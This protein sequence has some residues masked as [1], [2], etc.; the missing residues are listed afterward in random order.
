MRDFMKILAATLI[1]LPLIAA[2]CGGQDGEFWVNKD[3]SQ[4]GF[5]AS[6]AYVSA[7]AYIGE[8]AQVCDKAQIYGFAGLKGNVKVY[9]KARMFDA[10]YSSGRYY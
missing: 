1:T 5:V 7:S 2:P 4:G 8:N 3:G 9:G 10:T 6:T